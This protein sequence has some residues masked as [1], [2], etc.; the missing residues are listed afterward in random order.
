MNNDLNQNLI[1]YLYKRLY[2]CKLLQFEKMFFTENL[3]NCFIFITFIHYH[4]IIHILWGFA[5][6]Y[7]FFLWAKVDDDCWA[8]LLFLRNLK[9]MT[10][11]LIHNW[12]SDSYAY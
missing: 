3:K 1:I 9:L 5:C 12:S 10:I 6:T 7:W 8:N 2:N 4:L 11:K